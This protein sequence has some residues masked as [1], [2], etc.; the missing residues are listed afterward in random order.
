MVA[1]GLEYTVFVFRYSAVTLA[2]LYKNK[3]VLRYY[4]IGRYYEKNIQYS[5]L[6]AGW[7]YIFRNILMRY[8]TINFQKCQNAFICWI[9]I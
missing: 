6:T 2:C 9:N 1:I 3:S 4:E 8:F 7:T 5:K